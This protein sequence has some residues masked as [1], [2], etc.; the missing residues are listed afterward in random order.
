MLCLENSFEDGSISSDIIAKVAIDKNIHLKNK[1]SL[2][3]MPN[4]P[5]PSTYDASRIFY[6]RHINI[7]KKILSIFNRKNLIPKNLLKISNPHDIPG[8]WFKGPF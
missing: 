4:V 3:A 2:I 5:V 7:I 8:S 1:P 6:T